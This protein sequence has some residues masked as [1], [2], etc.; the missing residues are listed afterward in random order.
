[1]AN[2]HFGFSNRHV[3][4]RNSIMDIRQDCLLVTVALQSFGMRN[5]VSSCG[6]IANLFAEQKCI[7]SIVGL[8]LHSVI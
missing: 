5:S 1:M 6:H 3:I 4:C 8:F 7:I 2:L